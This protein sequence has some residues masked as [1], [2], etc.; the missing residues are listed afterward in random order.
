MVTVDCPWCEAPL[1]LERFEVLRCKDC[2]VE[3]EL[4]PDDAPDLALA[5]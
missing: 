3:V 2:R 4:A 5:A 1:A